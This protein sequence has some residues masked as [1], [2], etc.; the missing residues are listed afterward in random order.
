MNKT[1][2]IVIVNLERNKEIFKID[3]LD[4]YKIIKKF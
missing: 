1:N 3:L 2:Y 4:K